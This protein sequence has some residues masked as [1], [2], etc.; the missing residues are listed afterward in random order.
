MAQ[1]H[2]VCRQ[3]A[4]SQAKVK[5][6]EMENKYFKDFISSHV[7]TNDVVRNQNGQFVSDMTKEEKIKQMVNYRDQGWS[8]DQIA[9]ALNVQ[10]DTVRKYLSEYE[11]SRA[12]TQEVN[13]NAEERPWW[14]FC[15]SLSGAF[16]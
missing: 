4:E 8:D 12:H 3:L 9:S 7:K 16:K 1:Y 6:L 2:K 11:K 5:G 14:S 13:E 10:S 15:E